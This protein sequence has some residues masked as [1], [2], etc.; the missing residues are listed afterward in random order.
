MNSNMVRAEHVL[1]ASQKL[2]SEHV[3]EE[4]EKCRAKNLPTP[5][6]REQCIK[7]VADAQDEVESKVDDAVEAL[8]EYWEAE[9]TENKR[10]RTLAITKFVTA[11]AGLPKEYFGGATKQIMEMFYK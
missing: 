7:P 8:Q 5:E 4:V 9:A 6:E 3:D 2:W 1:G 10:A 11:V